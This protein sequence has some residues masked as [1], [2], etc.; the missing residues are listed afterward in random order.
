MRLEAVSFTWK[1]TDGY[2]YSIR[3]HV[4]G[5]KYTIGYVMKN[6]ANKVITKYTFDINRSSAFPMFRDAIDEEYYDKPNLD[7]FEFEKLTYSKY[8]PCDIG[9]YTYRKTYSHDMIA[10]T[11]EFLFELINDI[12]A[13]LYDSPLDELDQLEVCA[14]MIR[15]VDHNNIGNHL[16]LH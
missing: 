15:R 6:R 7:E 9:Q 13:L 3:L 1:D 2:S 11:K 10:P 5:P 4:Y 8:E 14:S 12:E 16:A